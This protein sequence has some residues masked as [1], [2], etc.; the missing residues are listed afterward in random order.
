MDFGSV[1]ELYEDIK[2]ENITEVEMILHYPHKENATEI[3]FEKFGNPGTFFVEF[4][5]NGSKGKKAY[6]STE[7]RYNPEDYLNSIERFNSEVEKIKILGNTAEMIADN[8]L[9]HGCKVC[10]NNKPYKPED[11]E[12]FKKYCSDTKTKIESIFLAHR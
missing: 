1:S 6:R 4:H 7:L 8:L 11:F 5:A 9:H 3:D 10:L 12:A 2:K